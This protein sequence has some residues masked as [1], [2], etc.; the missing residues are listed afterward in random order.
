[1]NRRNQRTIINYPADIISNGQRFGGII[2]NLSREGIGL[3]R[4]TN[5]WGLTGDQGK[6]P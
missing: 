6:F 2:A 1:M 4:K 3:S 5:G